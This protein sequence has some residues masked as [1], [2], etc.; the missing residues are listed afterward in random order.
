[1]ALEFYDSFTGDLNSGVVVKYFY[2]DWCGPC[3]MMAPYLEDVA[4]A[5]GVTIVKIDADK[6]RDLIAE[7]NLRSVPTMFFT[8][9]G[10]EV[11]RKSGFIPQQILIDLIK[12]I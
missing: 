7:H 3:K 11:E 4:N 8:R 9:D 1:M 5:T 6:H 10:E 2:A 12:S